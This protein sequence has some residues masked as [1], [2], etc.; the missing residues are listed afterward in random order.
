M[1][2]S[3]PF[4]VTQERAIRNHGYRNLVVPMDLHKDTKQKLTSVGNMAK[5]FNSKVILVSPNTTDTF[6]K[7]QLAGN[8]T[9]ATEYLKGRG[10]DYEVEILETKDPFIKG[11]LKYA[12]SIE[13]DMICIVNSNEYGFFSSLFSNHEETQ[14]ITNDAQIP[15]LCVNAVS[16]VA[17]DVN[18]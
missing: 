5:Y 3:V 15:V 14:V 17:P 7:N 11:M 9:F 6:L 8:I 16:V 4:I 18:Y 12:A 1:E 13:A 10:I 2:S